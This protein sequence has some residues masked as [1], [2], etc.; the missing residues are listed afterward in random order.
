MKFALPIAAGIVAVAVRILASPDLTND[1]FMHMAYAQ[2]LLFGEL[3]GR[4]FVDPGMPLA[5]LLSAGVQSLWQGPFSEL[6]LSALMVGIAAAATCL[7]ARRLSGS[8]L[9][10]IAVSLLEIAFQPRL[11][12]YPKVL[13]PAVAVLLIQHYFA[14]P[15]NGRLALVGGWTVLS[16][17]LRHDYAVYVVGGTVLALLVGHWKAWR[18]LGLAAAVY[19]GATLICALPYLVY[20]QWSEGIVE[21][22]RRGI[23]FSKADAHTLEYQLPALSLAQGL[24]R[25]A[26]MPLLFYATYA[27]GIVLIVQLLVARQS[28]ERRAA[29][30]AVTGLLAT[31]VVFILRYPL[32]QRIPDMGTVVALALA[33]TAGMLFDAFTHRIPMR[34]W[35]QAS[36]TLIVAVVAAGTVAGVWVLTNVSETIDKTGIYAG[37]RGLRE[38]FAKRVSAGSEWP[39]SGV[40][41]AGD[42]PAAVEYLDACTDPE[43]ALLITWR[44]PEYNFFAR[45][46]FAAGHAEFLAPRSFTSL[47]DQAQMLAWLNLHHTPIALINLATD[48]EFSRSYPLV[49]AYLRENYT[50]AGRFTI[51]DDSVI[52][53]AVRN[54]LQPASAWGPDGWPCSFAAT[55]E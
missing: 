44:A 33:A 16:A 28:I 3:P 22:L 39:W 23:E 34:R 2:Q 27:L 26:A 30:A 47:A 17:L 40:W 14:R 24:T 8:W 53:V 9:I 32:D 11:Y 49:Q 55:A 52:V 10:A 46:K 5:Y 6:V 21:H 42:M 38:T 19:A 41:P 36:L 25:D 54:G 43:D 18:A 29:T 7:A 15:T 13:V 4:D 51:Y 1:H 31:Y 35:A 12:A 37:V 48:D 50:P 45:R 20:V